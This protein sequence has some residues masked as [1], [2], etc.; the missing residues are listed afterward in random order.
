M[1]RVFTNQ[2]LCHVFISQSQNEGRNQTSSMYFEGNEIYSYGSHYL[3]GKIYSEDTGQV[4]LIN[5]DNYS[6]TT[7]KQKCYLRRAC[8]HIPSFEVPDPHEPNS[9]E[10]YTF[11]EDRIFQA[12]FEIASISVRISRYSHGR[13][14]I[15]N[16]KK[17]WLKDL[18]DEY[19][20]YLELFGLQ[21]RKMEVSEDFWNL[22]DEM[23]S[24]KNQ[25]HKEKKAYQETDEYKA[26]KEKAQL[27]KEEKERQELEL[28]E[29][30]KAE[31]RKR[32]FFKDLYTIR[33]WKRGKTSM[34]NTSVMKQIFLRINGNQVE[35]SE[36]ANV[37]LEDAIKLL[38][39]IDQ[40]IKADGDNIGRY[41]VDHVIY[42]K[43]AYRTLGHLL[44]IYKNL[45]DID[46]D[47]NQLND[48][49]FF[50]PNAIADYAHKNDYNLTSDEIVAISNA[51]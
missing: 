12:F 6:N 19:N 25:I 18:I 29:K 47:L 23:I 7:A 43:E 31:D 17:E 49:Y 32:R 40:K 9:A 26:K 35:T 48:K 13:E 1:K 24:Y 28:L 37:P 41:R 30:R 51:L 45:K 42:F 34:R 46:K 39:K 20:E 5:E 4:I 11:F 3:M 14:N 8:S 10:N 44:V 15:Y 27:E 21:K 50:S 33:L 38:Y 22:V 2:E 16:Y 36:S